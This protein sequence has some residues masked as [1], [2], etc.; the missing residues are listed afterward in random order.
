MLGKN[1]MEKERRRY[2]RISLSLPVILRYKGKL[3]PAKMV[4]LS[5]GGMGILSSREDF[6]PGNTVEIIFDLNSSFRDLSLRG[7]VS[8]VDAEDPSCFGIQ[9]SDFLSPSHQV[10]ENF[11][12]AHLH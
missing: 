6:S 12:R 7:N 3:L 9:F 11:V 5:Y 1:T 8:H 4:N 2:H 10:I